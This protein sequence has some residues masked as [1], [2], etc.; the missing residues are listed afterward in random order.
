M[1]LSAASLTVLAAS[2][3]GVAMARP[4]G[5]GH[6]ITI[7]H[8]TN[9]TKHP[10]VLITVKESAVDGQGGRG[11]GQGDHYGVHTGPVWEPGLPNG[12]DWGDIIPPIEG[13]HEGLN[14]TVRGEAIYGAGCDAT[15]ET[16][17]VGTDQ[18]SDGI[19]DATDPD[20]DNDGIIDLRD[21]EIDTDRDGT[22]DVSDPDDDN[23]GTLDSRDPDSDADGIPNLGDPDA[24]PDGDGIPNATDLDNDGDGVPDSREKDLDGD[25]IPNSSDPDDD[26]DGIADVSDTDDDN[27]GIPENTIN[28]DSDRD[29]IKDVVDPDDDND[30]TPDSRDSDSN[31]DGVKEVELQ[32]IVDPKVP[33]KIIPGREVTFGKPDYT[34]AGMQVTY[35]TTCTSASSTRM[36][37]RGDADATDESPTCVTTQSGDTVTVKVVSADP[38]KVRVVATAA[39]IGNFRALRKAWVFHVHM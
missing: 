33:T 19:P 2:S 27:N 29:G 15:G 4:D 24:D 23:D 18:D 25:G 20:D 26:G 38:V 32:R 14:W 8:R 3:A 11:E 36:R 10:Y 7:C 35:T 1:A 9:S 31:G 12:G 37:P 30:R 16:P 22:P 6:W 17:V 34:D 39:A 21:P 13:V 28:P 5:E